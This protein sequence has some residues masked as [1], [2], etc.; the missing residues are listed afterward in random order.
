M[1]FSEPLLVVVSSGTVRKSR[2]KGG[3]DAPD[4]SGWTEEDVT[5]VRE[6]HEG[7]DNEVCLLIL[8]EGEAGSSTFAGKLR[9]AC[10]TPKKVRVLDYAAP[11]PWDLE[12]DAVKFLTAEL[13]RRHK[14]ISQDIA[15]AVIGVVGTDLGVL[16]QEALKYSTYLDAMSKPEGAVDVG[17]VRGLVAGFGAIEYRGLLDA[18]GSRSVKGVLRA[19]REV[20]DG[21]VG[22]RGVTAVAR[23]VGTTSVGWLRVAALLDRGSSPDEVAAQLGWKPTRVQFQLP[24][25]RRW[26]VEGCKD[27]V[28][29]MAIVDRGSRLGHISPWVEF[30]VA[31]VR[32]VTG[33]ASL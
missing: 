13:G 4:K 33:T 27:L 15:V 9:D 31:L 22:S 30:E 3:E 1:L 8:H 7:G 17:V 20:Q 11:A 25:I 26:G 32:A 6:H 10:V 21:P 5:L 24:I 14:T 18:I 16:S 29:R 2:K 23:T 19:V 12:A 28:H